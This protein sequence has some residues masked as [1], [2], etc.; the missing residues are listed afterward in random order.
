MCLQ[1]MR[2]GHDV[3]RVFRLAEDGRLTQAEIATEVGVSQKTVSRWLRAGRDATLSSP[4]RRRG[5]ISGCPDACPCREA[6]PADAYAYLLGQYLGDGAIAHMRRG[7]YRL[8]LSCCAAYPDIV[9]ECRRAIAAVLPHNAI[10]QRAKP[11][12]LELTCY[13][14]HWPCLFP[15]HGSGHKHSR[16]IALERWQQHIALDQH[17]ERFVRGLIHSDGCRCINR[18]RGA[19]GQPYAYPR[20]L[21]S[22]RSADIRRLFVEACERLG[23]ECRQMNRYNI[24]VAQRPSVARLDEIVG[25]KT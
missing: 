3:Q 14:K 11:G 16:P 20:Y 21:F 6:V 4:M 5:D 22:N 1:C 12:V 15:Q 17:P 24:S 10:G 2:Q 25:P 8:F 19:N 23:V 13:S 9:A 7:V 18:V